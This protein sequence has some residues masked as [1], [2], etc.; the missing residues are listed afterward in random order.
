MLNVNK[1]EKLSD[2]DE[3]MKI[4]V[5]NSFVLLIILCCLATSHVF[6]QS[7]K[8]PVAPLQQPAADTRHHEHDSSSNSG[9]DDPG[10]ALKKGPGKVTVGQ[11][12][13][14]IPDLMVLDQ[15]GK[16]RRFYSDLIKNRVVVLSF[17]FTSCVSFCPV[18]AHSLSKL[19]AHLAGRLGKDVFI[20]TVT[21][22]PET[23]TPRRLREW[24]E[25]M[26][27]KPGWTMVTGE[28]GAVGKIVRDFT[29]DRLGK[30]SHETLFLIGSDKTG[31][32]I[33]A[34]GY[35]HPEELREHIETV[36]QDAK[37]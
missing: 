37:P 14:A 24:G 26:G 33:D 19:Q 15:Y 2:A 5:I 32:W 8:M 12:Q 10:R 4:Y 34:S 18:M 1:P 23:D 22:D 3:G 16:R 30:D 20:I 17:F 35:T 21:K 25:R 9:A 11:I 36:R 13:I 29:G 28:A 6:G 31:I 7:M 27:V